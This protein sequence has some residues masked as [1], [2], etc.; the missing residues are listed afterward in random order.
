MPMREH[1]YRIDLEGLIWFDGEWYEEPKVY[2]LFLA[3]MT[4]ADD[5]RLYADCMG[6][7]CWVIPEDTPFVVQRVEIP[8]DRSGATMVLTGEIELPLDPATLTVGRDNVLY[9]SVRGFA[10][11][12]T[13]KAY[14]ELARHI[15]PKNGAFVLEL[16]GR[17][18]PIA[19]SP[20]P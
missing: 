1:T 12:F 14:Y 3:N 16:A 18:W 6:E 4:R 13:R 9:T 15:A 7:R 8:A 17:T 5:G 11:R 10:T 20:A 19:G 2:E